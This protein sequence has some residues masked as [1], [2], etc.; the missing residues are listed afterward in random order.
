MPP[1]GK[2]QYDSSHVPTMQEGTAY[3][4]SAPNLTATNAL[5]LSALLGR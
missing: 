2:Y 4:K 1:L 3:A 5:A